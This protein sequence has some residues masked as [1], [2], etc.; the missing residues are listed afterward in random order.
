MKSSPKA[1]NIKF[2][3]THCANQIKNL[4]KA[5]KY[6]FSLNV[7]EPSQFYMYICNKYISFVNDFTVSRH[8]YHPVIFTF[9]ET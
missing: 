8:Y 5:L 9:Y 7:A 2:T 1:I 6:L 3:E 4:K